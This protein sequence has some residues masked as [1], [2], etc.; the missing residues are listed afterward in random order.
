MSQETVTF[1]NGWTAQ[2]AR[3]AMHLDASVANLNTGSFGPLPRVVLERAT[4]LRRR[5]AEEPM[6]F[7][8]RQ[9]PPLLWQAREKLASFLAAD[10]TRMIFTANVSN[11]INIVASGLTLPE[12]GEIL[13]TDH[14]YGAM[15][16]CWQRAAQRQGLA[17]RTFPLPIQAEDPAE[18]VA[19]FVR[20]MNE[21]TRLLFFSQVLSP[22]GLVLPAREICAEARRR[23]ILSVVDGAHA[24]AMVPLDL[25]KINADFYGANCHKWLLAPCGSGFL[26][27]GKG[28][29]D[30]LQPMQVSWGFHPDRRRMDERDESGSTPRIRFYEFEGTRDPAAWLAV[31]AAIEFQQQLGF[32]RIRACNAGLAAHVRRRF[33]EFPALRPITP[34]HAELHGFL[35][36][37]RLPP[38]TDIQRWRKV[39]WEKYRVEVPIP[40]RPEGP[41]L[42]VSTH[43]YNTHE[44]I[45]LLCQAVRDL[46]S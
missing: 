41:I 6:D 21:R 25:E 28:N 5:Q 2:Q 13:L 29:E 9:L 33:A 20:A 7:L 1:A 3:E 42:R 8:L 36:A 35:T 11:S 17:F 30:R 40:E 24:P 10:P 31:P 27:L 14:E 15:H 43:F 23:G 34:V 16:W 26:Y 45:D 19:A 12:P 4:Q 39:L 37:Y 46:L 22:T 44:E 32:E 38:G 18:I